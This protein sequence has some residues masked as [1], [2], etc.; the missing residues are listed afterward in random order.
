MPDSGQGNVA[1]LE[2]AMDAAQRWFVNHQKTLKKTKVRRYDSQLGRR[3]PW[4][5]L[6]PCLLDPSKRAVT[7]TMRRARPEPQSR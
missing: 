4:D 5:E 6:L 3:R 2:E 1:K 7:P